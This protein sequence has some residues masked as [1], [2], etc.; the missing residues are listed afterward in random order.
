[1]KY[2]SVLSPGAK[3]EI[4]SAARWYQ[5]IDPNLAFR[6][7]QETFA[8]LRRIEKSPYHFRIVD[9]K[10]RRALLKHFPYS[11]FFTLKKHGPFVIAVV[12]Q[13]RSDTIWRDRTNSASERGPE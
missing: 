3:A 10:T 7:R 12:H 2:R 8:T 4:R 1:M 11:I 13:R 9:G 6:F 5:R